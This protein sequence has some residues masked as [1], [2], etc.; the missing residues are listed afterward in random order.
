[1]RGA[2]GR[3]GRRSAIEGDLISSC[4]T[5]SEEQGVCMCLSVGVGM[6][7]MR[8]SQS[9]GCGVRYGPRWVNTL[10]ALKFKPRLYPISMCRHRV[11]EADSS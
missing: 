8:L 10:I 9:E 4:C 2:S 7:G 6:M 5:S 3:R 11:R 1:M